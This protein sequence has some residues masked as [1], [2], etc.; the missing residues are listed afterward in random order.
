MRIK[1]AS[2]KGD[3]KVQEVQEVQEV[4]GT[5][6]ELNMGKAAPVGGFGYSSAGAICPAAVPFK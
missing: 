6:L 3:T 5:V 4:Q 1:C 2:V